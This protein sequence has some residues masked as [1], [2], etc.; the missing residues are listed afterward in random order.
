MPPVNY[1]KLTPPYKINIQGDLLK[2]LHINFDRLERPDYT[3]QQVIASN[4]ADEWP[5]DTPGR[6]M[7]AWAHLAVATEQEPRYLNE[8]Y[9]R[10]PQHL[11][12]LGYMGPVFDTLDE[13]QLS[14]HGWLTA[15]LLAYYNYTGE[16]TALDHAQRI[17]DNLFLKLRG[18][19]ASYPCNPEQRSLEG[20]PAGARARTING[21]TLSTDI[22]CAFISLEGLVK[23][24]RVFRRES[25]KD[26]IEEMFES[27]KHIDLMAISAQLHASLTATRQFLMYHDLSPEPE[28]LEHAQKVYGLFRQHAITE[29]YANYNWFN[30]PGWTE[31]CAVVDAFMLAYELWRKTGEVAFLDDAHHIYFNAL[32]YGQ[33]PH[34]GFGC[35]NCVGADSPF[36]FNQVYDV[37]WCC[38]MRGAIGLAQ[39]AQYAYGQSQDNII[40]PFYFDSTAEFNFGDEH[41][42][43]EQ[44]TEY[45]YEGDTK[46]TVKRSTLTSPKNLHFY[47]PSWVEPQTVRIYVDG[48]NTVFYI[49]NGFAVLEDC[50]LFPGIHIE[51]NYPIYLRQE[52][53]INSKH[54]PRHSTYRRGPLILGRTL[55][56]GETS[57]SLLMLAHDPQQLALVPLNNVI[58]LPTKSAQFERRQILFDLGE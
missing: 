40:V 53:I 19:M 3:P 38:N 30:R 23:A 6:T 47:L 27:F 52:P 39:A 24:H 36:L 10:L 13:Q 1:S 56:P 51:L 45:P 44:V 31:P 11:N 55:Q 5:G 18:K 8:L 2:R 9:N 58:D 34:G 17:V 46:F 32:G 7:L 28:I 54:L 50:S 16:A 25:E 14:G 4:V 48:K 29:N 15:G 42:T 26:L 12:E 22:G 43:L 21:W 20:L 57:D 35:D 33:K 49:R 37:T 41:L